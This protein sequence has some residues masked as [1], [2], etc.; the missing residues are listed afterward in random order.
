M[1]DYKPYL[2]E[3]EAQERLRRAFDLILK[4]RARGEAGRGQKIVR[5]LEEEAA[6]C[7]S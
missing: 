7:Q 6:K 4:A 3:I 1:T 5:K 2:D